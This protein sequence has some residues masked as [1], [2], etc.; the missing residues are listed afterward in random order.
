MLGGSTSFIFK[1][2]SAIFKCDGLAGV[3]QM[4]NLDFELACTVFLKELVGILIKIAKT[5][6]LT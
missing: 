2:V 3:K 5:L 4:S 6:H 1:L